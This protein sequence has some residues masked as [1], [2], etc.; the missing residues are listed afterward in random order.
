MLPGMESENTKPDPGVALGAGNGA[1][2][3]EFFLRTTMKRRS[4]MFKKVGIF[5]LLGMIVLMVWG[6]VINGVFGFNSRINMRQISDER[7]V[8]E[9]LK[10][11]VVEPGRYIFN[12]ELTPSGML[13]TG[14][15]GL[16]F[17]A[18]FLVVLRNLWPL[19]IAHGLINTISFVDMFLNG[20]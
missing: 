8:Y 14:A 9:S 17:G 5:A 20:I 1:W 13:M 16:L 2:I 18:V 7:K 10:E 4:K 19:V 11:S 3:K 12:P 6:F 15:T